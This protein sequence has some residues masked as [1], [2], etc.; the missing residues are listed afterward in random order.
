[1]V[2]EDTGGGKKMRAKGGAASAPSAAPASTG[3]V[4]DDWED[5]FNA[6]DIV[7]QDGSGKTWRDD[8][9]ITQI[10]AVVAGLGPGEELDDPNWLDK[11]SDR[12]FDVL[13]SNLSPK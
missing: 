8:S 9:D 2:H 5:Q 10:G 6:G 13:Q 12:E 1:M 3:D 11:V 4:P 7:G